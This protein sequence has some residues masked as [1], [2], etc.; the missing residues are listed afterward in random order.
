[1]ASRHTAPQPTRTRRWASMKKT[2]DY[3]G[4][5]ER[6]VRQMITD[7]RLTGYRIGRTRTVRLDLNEVDDIMQ[8]FGG[9][10]NR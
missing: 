1:M 6:T 4:L 10:V 8:S 7:G 3:M 9:G 5:A 2:A